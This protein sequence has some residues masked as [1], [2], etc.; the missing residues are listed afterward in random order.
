MKFSV[1]S[2]LTFLHNSP[3][4]GQFDLHDIKD[5]KT[6]LMRIISAIK[7]LGSSRSR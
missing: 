7:F 1:I 5:V 2:N 6:A 4:S 3:L